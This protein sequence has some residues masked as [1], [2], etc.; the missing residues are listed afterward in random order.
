MFMNHNQP[1][2][3]IVRKILSFLLVV[4]KKYRKAVDF[5]MWPVSKRVLGER[6]T[7]VLD[8]GNGIRMCVYGDMYDMSNKVLMFYADRVPFAWEPATTRLFVALLASHKK[9]V[10]L[11]GANLG[12]Y[13]LVAGQAETKRAIHAFEP[14]GKIYER[15][16]ANVEL[17]GFKNIVPHHA[18]L[19]DTDGKIHMA[20]D[21]AQSSVVSDAAAFS[22]KPTETVESVALDSLFKTQ[23]EHPDLIL[24]DVEGY[25]L[26]ALNGAQHILEKTA[27]DVIFEVNRT[28]L[29]ES[30]VAVSRIIEK[31]T[32]LG[33]NLFLIRDDY[34]AKGVV[35]LQKEYPV[36]L[37]DF[38]GP[39]SQS[40]LGFSWVNVLATKKSKEEVLALLKKRT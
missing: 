17:N 33:Y 30:G 12:Y 34:N 4:L 39:M 25:E 32:K 22:S 38:D 26:F 6:F 11:A 23:E 7:E 10:V 36:E 13:A 15:F 5:I 18:A 27:P 21:N 9:S 35:S 2:R 19:S 3:R 1:I 20:V 40:L 31:F 29:E 8:I 28:G 37:V 14:V 24:L 16:V